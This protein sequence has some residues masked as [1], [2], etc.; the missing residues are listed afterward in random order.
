MEDY[1]GSITMF[2]FNWAPRSYASCHGQLMAI[3]QNT[4]LFSLLGTNFG[5]NGQSTFG[6]P[7]LRGRVPVGEGQGPGLTPRMLG[8]AFGRDTMALSANNLAPHTHTIGEQQ[9]NQTAVLHAKNALGDKGPPSGHYVAAG[10]A[11]DGS[12]VM[13]FSDAAPDSTLASD[14]V[15]INAGN[16]IANATGAGEEFP[17]DQPSLVVGYAICTQGIFPSR[18]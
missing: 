8:Q 17:V 18:N 9:A 12:G 7:D 14:A 3:N 11:T 1:I 15:T 2:A 13:N 16:L 6:L 4:A 10:R 5:G